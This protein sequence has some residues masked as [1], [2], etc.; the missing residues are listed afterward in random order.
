MS[1]QCYIVADLKRLLKGYEFYVSFLGVAAVL[2]FSLEDV[3]VS[4]AGVVFTYVFA[5][6][7]TGMMLTYVFCAWPFATVFCEDLERK[8]IRYAVGR[9]NLKSYVISKIAVIYSSSVV[10][11]IIGTVFFICICRTKVPWVDWKTM[12]FPVLLAGSYGNLLSEGHYF[13]YCILFALQLGFFAGTLS[14]SAAFLSTYISNK[15]TVLVF[16]VLIYQ[17]LAE[18]SR[19]GIHYSFYFRAYNKILISNW[20]N[21]IGV[22]LLSIIPVVF[23]TFGTYKKLQTRL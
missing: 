22:F 9:G 7:M 15:V 17:I 16:P 6:D 1:K 10:S 4:D 12:D 23:L 11:M 14:V 21:I 18:C 8:Y 13:S 5:T 3:G 2:F 19:I 20:Q